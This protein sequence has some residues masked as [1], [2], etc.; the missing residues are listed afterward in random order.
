MGE[1]TI[2]LHFNK[3]TGKKDILVKYESEDDALPFEHEQ[4]HWKIVEDLINKGV[5]KPEDVGQ[6]RVGQ[7]HGQA[8]PKAE[9]QQTP[10]PQGQ[11]AGE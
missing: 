2:H 7:T 3:E 5:L 10:S 9:D 11:G 1:I 4:R 6:L 8:A